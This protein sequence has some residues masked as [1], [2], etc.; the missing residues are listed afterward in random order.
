MKN[1]LVSSDKKRRAGFVR[2]ELNR[3]RLRY[4]L[5]DSKMVFGLKF[6]V[7]FKFQQY[8]RRSSC[9]GLVNRCFVSGRSGSVYRS[10]GLSRLVLRKLGLKGALAG[11]RKSS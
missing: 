3:L 8:T 6:F 10:F 9:V 2:T 4:V 1:Y 7:F 11:V 5:Q